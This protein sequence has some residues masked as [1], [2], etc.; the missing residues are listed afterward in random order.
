MMKEYISEKRNWIIFFCVLQG[1]FLLVGYVDPSIRFQ[2]ILY[3][4][5]LSSVLFILFLVFQ[6]NR[7]ISFYKKVEEW[8]P[9]I[10]VEMLEGKTPFEAIVEKA[11]KQQDVYYKRVSNNLAISI[12]KEKDELLAWIHEVKTPLTTMQLMLERMDDKVLREQLLYEWLRIHLLL[13]QQL[14]SRRLP[15]MEND[16]YIE[17]IDMEKIIITEIRSLKTWCFQK[18]IGFDI[19]LEVTDVLSD[20]KWLPFILR[21][22]L[23]NAVKYSEKSDIQIRSFLRHGNITLEVEDHGRGIQTKDISRIFEKGFT[24]TVDHQNQNATG[25][26]LYLSKKAAESLK[27]KIDVQSVYGKGTIFTLT[28]PKKN[29]FIELTGM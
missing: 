27:I 8:A 3:M 14:H 2:S 26:G 29:D 1:L 22:I 6:Y 28:F 24:S 17:A 13:D 12:E 16:L 18:E 7:E 4:I 20:S 10:D 11:I 9:N 19:K 5:F 21:Q 15:F 25:M 23:T